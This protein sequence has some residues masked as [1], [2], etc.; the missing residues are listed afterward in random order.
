M[1][2]I[3][4]QLNINSPG[5]LLLLS[6]SW[7]ILLLSACAGGPDA[8]YKIR[9]IDSGLEILTGRSEE[10]RV[11]WMA[12]RS[13]SAELSISPALLPDSL[14]DVEV[15]S[16]HAADHFINPAVMA[17]LTASPHNPIRF[18]SG[19]PQDVRGY[20]RVDGV[21]YSKPDGVHDAAAVSPDGSPG[22]LS[23]ED[24]E[25]WSGDSAGGFY[26]ILIDGTPVCPVSVRDTVSAAGWSSDGSILI[27]M[28][29][30][31]RNGRGY[32]YEE[33]GAVLKSLGAR[34]GI[35]MDGGGSARLV[36]RED[37][38]LISFPAA[39]F[40]RAVPNHLLLLK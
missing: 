23:P 35:A 15:L 37:G 24:Q 9:E 38:N 30:K 5:K 40:F 26:A 34:N 36:W 1:G 25:K 11:L 31:G 3:N 6:A 28:V 18:L 12:V 8:S 20:Y 29:I 14:N 16:R 4:N 33:A 13:D 2:S 19:L 27:L 10:G 17:A 39:L 22:I 21:T 32:S 7:I